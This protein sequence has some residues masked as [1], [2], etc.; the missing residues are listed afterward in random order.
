L[1]DIDGC[2]RLARE[3]GAFLDIELEML[4]ESLRDWAGNPGEPYTLVERREGEALEGFALVR[5]EASTEFTFDVTA[6]CLASSRA[7]RE[8]GA[9]LLEDVE[10]EALRGEVSAIV[11]FEMSRRR[12]KAVDRRLLVESG[13][14][15]IGHIPDFYGPGDDY[16]MYAKH[17]SSARSDS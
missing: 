6:F 16:F 12:E 1:T 11:R 2:L 7:V 4:T 10:R 14:A 17:V 15:L 3:T 8:A 13:Y 9:R 5:R